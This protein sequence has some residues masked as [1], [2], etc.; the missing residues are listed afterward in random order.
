MTPRPDTTK[1]YETINHAVRSTVWW[2]ARKGNG[3][4]HFLRKMGIDL[5]VDALTKSSSEDAFRVLL[6][7]AVM[8]AAERELAGREALER[9]LDAVF[10]YEAFLG[11]A[12]RSV[13]AQKNL[14]QLAIYAAHEAATAHAAHYV[15]PEGL[16]RSLAIDIAI[17]RVLEVDIRDLWE[18][19]RLGKSML[20]ADSTGSILAIWQH[21]HAQALKAWPMFVFFDAAW[22]EERA[23]DE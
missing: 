6:M 15:W 17:S 19:V 1:A 21:Y 3:C 22:P 14:I 18:L 13:R 23:Q 9:G 5:C 10:E 4:S 16:P 11:D 7:G 20:V 2:D 8:Q 12:P